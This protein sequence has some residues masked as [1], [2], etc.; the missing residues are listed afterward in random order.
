[1]Q[2][3]RPATIDIVAMADGWHELTWT[4]PSMG[5]SMVVYTYRIRE[6]SGYR[7]DP[8]DGAAGEYVAIRLD[9]DRLTG[10]FWNRCHDWHIDMMRIMGAP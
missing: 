6:G 10:L 5:G 3:P 2:P 4:L 8:P 1:M 7:T 9:A